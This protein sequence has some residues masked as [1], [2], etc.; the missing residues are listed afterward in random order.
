MNESPEEL[1]LCGGMFSYILPRFYYSHPAYSDC[2]LSF[3]SLLVVAP[4]CVL[5][6]GASQEVECALIPLMIET[7]GV[8]EVP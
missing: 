8:H 5:Q 3:C 6:L 1:F 4:S 7:F 2:D